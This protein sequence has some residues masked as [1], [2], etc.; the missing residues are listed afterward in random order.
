MFKLQIFTH[1][2]EKM[3]NN[4]W[5]K[6]V[7]EGYNKPNRTFSKPVQTE[8]KHMG[9]T[10]VEVRN[11]DV[12]GALRRLKKILERDDRQKALARKEFF[13]KPTATRK[14]A[15]AAAKS[16]WARE[17]DTNRRTG[18]WTDSHNGTSA[19]WMR[20]KKKRRAHVELQKK[21]ASRGKP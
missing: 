1:N 5:S 12:N 17:V 2:K 16:R 7:R 14:R 10:S 18:T 9:G 3:K 20:T 19:S 13:E 11:D 21:I 6:E 15:K 4:N 8:K